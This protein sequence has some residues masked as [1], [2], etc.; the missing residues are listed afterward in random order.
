MGFQLVQM[1][2]FSPIS[3]RHDT[4]SPLSNHC[5]E[6]KRLSPSRVRCS[7]RYLP[8]ELSAFCGATAKGRLGR[9]E[10]AHSC[11]CIAG[12]AC[13]IFLA[14]APLPLAARFTSYEIRTTSLCLACMVH[15]AFDSPTSQI[16]LFRQSA[17]LLYT[18]A[19]R[20]STLSHRI[21]TTVDVPGNTCFMQFREA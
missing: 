5:P 7:V 12:Y 2:F 17:G 13:A 4:I 18:A 21:R 8:P 10:Y 9:A 19:R 14:P 6:L 16:L 11:K 3:G 15:D 20:C 1:G